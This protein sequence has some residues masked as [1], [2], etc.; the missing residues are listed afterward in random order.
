MQKKLIFFLFVWNSLE[1]RLKSLQTKSQP[2]DSNN[3]VTITT[4]SSGSSAVRL[5]NNADD[6][7][8]KSRITTNSTPK[9]TTTSNGTSTINLTGPVTDL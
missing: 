9:V 8:G 3:V 4:G 1:Y 2:M 7:M 6:F 5:S